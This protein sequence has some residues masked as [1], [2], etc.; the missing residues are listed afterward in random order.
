MRSELQRSLDKADSL[1]ALDR[2][3]GIGLHNTACRL[4][5]QCGTGCRVRLTP[6]QP[7]GL[8]VTLW[9]PFDGGNR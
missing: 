5:L 1:Q 2:E 4:R 7:C 9:L 6:R 8:C 3:H